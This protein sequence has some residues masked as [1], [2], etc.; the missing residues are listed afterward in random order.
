MRKTVASMILLSVAVA[1]VLMMGP[2][3]SKADD[4][5]AKPETPPE[6]ATSEGAAI[7]QAKPAKVTIH[8]QRKKKNIFTTPHYVAVCD[9]PDFCDGSS[10]EWVI[11]G[12]LD[13]GETLTIKNA[14]GYPQCFADVIPVAVEAPNNGAESGWPDESCMEEKYGTFWPYVI[15]MKLAD[16]TTFSTDPGGIIHKRR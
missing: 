11:A 6:A 15:E 1:A 4:K 2:S 3:C 7:I 14:P 12:R 9:D 8:I 16:G 13:E 10:F 5:E